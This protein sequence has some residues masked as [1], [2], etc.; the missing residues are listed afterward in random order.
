MAHC[1]PNPILMF[2]GVVHYEY[3]LGV[4]LRGS[5]PFAQ[6]IVPAPRLGKLSEHPCH[7]HLPMLHPLPPAIQL[8]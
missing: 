8:G 5:E 4:N 2:E 6:V 7:S 3:R 1:G